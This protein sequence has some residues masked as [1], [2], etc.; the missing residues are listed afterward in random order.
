MADSTN[1]IWLSWETH[2]RS[3]NL[4]ARL[5]ADL[6]V[7]DFNERS[8]AARYFLSAFSTIRSLLSTRPGVVIAQNPSLILCA[9]LAIVKPA[10]RYRFVIDAHN[11]ALDV[12]EASGMAGR[13]ARWVFAAADLAIVTNP[14]AAERVTACPVAVLPDPVGAIPAH[15]DSTE[16]LEQYGIKPNGYLLLICSFD[17]DEPVTAVIDAVLAMPPE[18]RPTLCLTGKRAKA[19]Q[20]ILQRECESIIFLD[21]LPAD[22]Y[23]CLIAHARLL[24]DLTTYDDG[25]VCGFAESIAVGVPILLSDNR[26]SQATFENSALYTKNDANSIR[27]SIESFL[28]NGVDALPK[29]EDRL[30]QFSRRWD[31]WFA[32]CEQAIHNGRAI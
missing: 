31:N 8:S 18:N 15:A 12:T 25:L 23:E 21:Y 10:F 11:H 28:S 9:M 19:A 7:H 3:T 20:N 16:I 2:R 26:V 4:A 22:H 32:Q 6:I 5:K 30:E 27:A 24:I 1:T 13:I 14:V 29:A 17:A